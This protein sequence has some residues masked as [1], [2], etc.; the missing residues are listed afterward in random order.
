MV[1]AG[2]RCK[3]EAREREDYINGD[4]VQVDADGRPIMAVVITRDEGED[5]TV[6]APCARAQGESLMR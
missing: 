4:D 3:V 6:Y 5:V 2:Q 1:P